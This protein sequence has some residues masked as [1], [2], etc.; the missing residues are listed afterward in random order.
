MKN[1]LGIIISFM[2]IAVLMLAAKYFEKNDKEGS[3]KFIH[4]LLANWWLIVMAFF[5][6]I[7]IALILPIAFVIINFISYKANVIKVM[8]RDEKDKDGLGT[9]YYA[10]SLI[11]LV[12]LSFGLTDNKLIGLVGLFVMAYGDGFAALAGKSITSKKYKIFG[13]QK[14]IA[15]SLIMFVI[16]FIIMISVFAYSNTEWYILKSIVVAIVSTVLEAVSVKGTDNLTVP[17]ITSI[18]T[19]FM[20]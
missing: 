11:P 10:I 2:Y 12:I 3:R 15:G 17:I 6:N 13:T 4:I 7:I 9:V 16:S 18:M 1:F 8:E 19:Y 14:T 5:N 20:I